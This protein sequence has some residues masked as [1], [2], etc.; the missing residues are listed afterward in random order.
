MTDPDLGILVRLEGMPVA[1]GRP[2]MTRAGHVYT[3]ARTRNYENQLRVHAIE[4]MAGNAPLAGAVMLCV[5]VGV[6]IPTS[7]SKRRRKAAIGGTVKATT[8][9]DLDNYIKIALDALQGVVFMN[10]SQVTML[11]ANKEYA[12]QPFLHALTL[13]LE[14]LNEAPTPPAMDAA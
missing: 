7:W 6:P 1:K 11:F 10:D 9:P 3:P 12:E 4:M 2:R 13:P 5:R 8:R 14:G